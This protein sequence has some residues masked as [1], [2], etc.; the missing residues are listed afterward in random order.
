MANHT[1]D[2][3]VDGVLDTAGNWD[4]IPDAVQGVL[5]FDAGQ[6]APAGYM[7]GTPPGT[8]MTIDG[9]WGLS[10]LLGAD[11]ALS[12][13]LGDLGN[14]VVVDVTLVT[15]SVY[16]HDATEAITGDI[17][18]NA[19]TMTVSANAAVGG[20]VA[21]VGSTYTH[22]STSTIT[23]AVTVD[24]TSTYNATAVHTLT[25][26]ITVD[27]GAL[28]LSSATLT[29]DVDL[30]GDATL[31]LGAACGIVGGV[32]TT[33]NAV[34]TMAAGSSI[35]GSFDAD[36]DTVDWTGSSGTNTLTVDATSDLVL[37]GAATGLDINVEGT[38]ITAT[39][40]AAISCLSLTLTEGTYVAAQTH[41]VATNQSLTVAGTSTLTLTDVA[42]NVQVT[43][44]TCT[45]GGALSCATLRIESGA[46]LDADSN[47][48][49]L[50]SGRITGYGTLK[51]LT[52]AGVIHVAPG[53]ADGGGNGAYVIFD[54]VGLPLV[55]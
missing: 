5:I 20:T 52:P 15:A 42:L 47:S 12:D 21:L 18:L 33:G 3:A 29:S 13:I 34:V 39:A 36:N 14:Q 44:G 25:G 16:D 46:I 27:G 8:A 51:T 2:G 38:G 45:L 17:S 26:G 35:T 28:T 50:A 48:M 1:Y 37:G 11:L 49:T 55:V 32:V 22:Q 6:N 54:T 30:L 9:T 10:L 24:A 7:D 23:G 43:A 40:G 41:T 4:A 31:T 19:S 53:V